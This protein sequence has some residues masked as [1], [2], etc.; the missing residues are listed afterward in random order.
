[1]KL[2]IYRISLII[3]FTLLLALGMFFAINNIILV[4]NGIRNDNG[5]LIY[6]IG[7]L[8]G[9]LFLG[10][11]IFLVAKSFKHGT[12]LLHTLCLKDNSN[13]KRKPILIM[14]C[15]ILAVIV[16]F[17]IINVLFYYKVLVNSFVNPT[18]IDFNFYFSLIILFNAVA[19]I[20]YYLFIAIDDIEV[21]D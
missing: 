2:K 20:I 21:I 19:L 1:M 7:M 17:L 18:M 6:L 5:Y 12:S 14:A 8:I 13:E 15:S 16:T 11:E 3:I 4:T 10:F 9:V